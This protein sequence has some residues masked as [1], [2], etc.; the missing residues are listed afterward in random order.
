MTD[1]DAKLSGEER[2]SKRRRAF[3]RYLIITLVAFMVAAFFSGFI[4]RSYRDGDVSLWV[5]MLAGA[6][7]LVAMIWFT[8]DFF[9]R[10]DELDLM[11]NLWAHLIGQYG[12]VF[13]FMGWYFLA[14][15]GLLAS[16]PTAISVIII[17]LVTTFLAYGARKLGFR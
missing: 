8:W 9:R 17:M 16:Y 5:P 14:D 3:W 1:N 12:A 2:Y 4:Q 6:A 15:L 11:D 10:V 7:L 13:G